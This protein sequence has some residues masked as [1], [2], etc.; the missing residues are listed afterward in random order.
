MAEVLGF[1]SLT[2]TSS[3]NSLIIETLSL[4]AQTNLSN[5]ELY[6]SINNTVKYLKKGV[7]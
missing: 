4:L 6:Y 5:D 3:Y 2:S 7:Q 1:V